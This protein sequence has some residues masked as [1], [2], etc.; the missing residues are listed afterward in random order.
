MPAGGQQE[1]EYISGKAR[2]AKFF[3]PS[4]F[5]KYAVDINLDNASLGKVLELKKRGIK[6][7]IKK[8]EDGYWI[9]LSS[10][11]RIDTRTGPKVM[12]PPTVVNKDGSPWDP[13]IGIGNG[14]D[15]ICKVWIRS[16][17]NP[18]T[19]TPETAIRLY[20]VKIENHVPFNP[21]SDFEDDKNR[22]QS[23]GLVEQEPQ[24]W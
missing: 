9:T 16:Y 1:Y 20:G 5:N 19:Q 21:K 8:D 15:V 11:S 4:K 6:N 10:P 14:S 2:W 13:K 3:V 24:I 7:K 12:Q 23:Q 17:K 18:S 22:L